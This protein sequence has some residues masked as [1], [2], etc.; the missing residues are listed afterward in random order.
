MLVVERGGGWFRSIFTP[1]HP[2]Q[3]TA[4]GWFGPWTAV[5]RVVVTWRYLGLGK[6]RVSSS[7]WPDDPAFRQP[8]QISY[9]TT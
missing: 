7:C 1:V 9:I 8:G 2:N 4:V 3:R 5:R 6:D